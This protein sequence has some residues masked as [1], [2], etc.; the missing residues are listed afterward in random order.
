M[1]QINEKGFIHSDLHDLSLVLLP[2]A[3]L[4][5]THPPK[6]CAD[7]PPNRFSGEV[8][9][10]LFGEEP[11]IATTRGCGSGCGCDRITP[12]TSMKHP[13]MK[14][15]NAHGPS[16]GEVGPSYGGVWGHKSLGPEGPVGLFGAPGLLECSCFVSIVVMASNLAMRKKRKTMK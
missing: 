16:Y 13:D 3:D 6:T 10:A 11:G 14:L 2:P 7:G 8:S 15:P 9:D 1:F 4:V 5:A 12:T